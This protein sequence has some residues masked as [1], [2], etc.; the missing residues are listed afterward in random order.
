M[1]CIETLYF[2]KKDQSN[3]INVKHPGFRSIFLKCSKVQRIQNI[4]PLV[5]K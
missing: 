3:Q 1:P 4:I 5:A 2:F